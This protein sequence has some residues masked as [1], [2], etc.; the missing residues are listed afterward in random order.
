[1]VPC[2]PLL[3]CCF[4]PRLCGIVLVLDLHIQHKHLDL[5]YLKLHDLVHKTGRI[6]ID[7]SMKEGRISKLT[8]KENMCERAGE[9]R[10]IPVSEGSLYTW[11]V[12]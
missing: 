4:G 2:P 8:T 6:L 5:E 9:R 1:M 11:S 7:D 3:E 10:C 12:P